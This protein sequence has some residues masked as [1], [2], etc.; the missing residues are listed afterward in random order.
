VLLGNCGGFSCVLEK[1]A[2]SIEC[3]CSLFSSSIQSRA[4]KQKTAMAGVGG[5]GS[6]AGFCP[7]PHLTGLNQS[8]YMTYLNE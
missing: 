7:T 6:V 3:I 5:G 1:W 2:A 8:T 4:G